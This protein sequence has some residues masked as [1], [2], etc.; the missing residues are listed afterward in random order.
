MGFGLPCGP[1]TVWLIRACTPAI[2]GAAKEVPPAPDQLRGA[3]RHGAPWLPRSEKQNTR[4]CPHT[5]FE[6]NMETSGMSR[7]PS[8][9]IPDSPV[10]QEGLANPLQVPLTTP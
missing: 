5:P 7:T 9:G 8:F 3:P 2:I 10:C 4:K 6:A 1:P